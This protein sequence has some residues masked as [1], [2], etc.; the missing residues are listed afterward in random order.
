MIKT[1]GCTT[2][3][4]A[5]KRAGLDIAFVMRSATVFCPTNE[6]FEN[7]PQRTEDLLNYNLNTLYYVVLYH[8]Y[9][10]SQLK[11]SD[12]KDGLMLSTFVNQRSFINVRETED[13][14]SSKFCWYS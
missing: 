5:A 10:D 12:L 2:F 13:E 3:H 14:V 11:S 8:M 1:E 9:I 6:A 4:H 7:L